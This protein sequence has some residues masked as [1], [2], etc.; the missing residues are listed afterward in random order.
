[1]NVIYTLLLQFI[2]QEK[3][4]SIGI[5]LLSLLINLFQINGISY[6]T[7][8]IITFMQDKN[9]NLVNTYFNYFILASIAFI[10]IYYLYKILQLSLIHI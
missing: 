10:I 5:L 4:K 9:Y 8:N 2:Q 6:I 3:A 7:A 1:M